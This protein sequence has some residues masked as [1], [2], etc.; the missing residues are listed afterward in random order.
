MPCSVSCAAS[1]MQLKTTTP[2]GTMWAKQ[3]CCGCPAGKW[4][5]MVETPENARTGAE[6][7]AGVCWTIL[8]NFFGWPLGANYSCSLS[9]YWKSELKVLIYSEQAH[10]ERTFFVDPHSASFCPKTNRVLWCLARVLQEGLKCNAEVKRIKCKQSSENNLIS[11]R[12][13]GED[14]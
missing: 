1:R 9:D 8:I 7:H 11:Y 12:Y 13:M 6:P 14:C 10:Y 5:F 2:A 3:D 4:V